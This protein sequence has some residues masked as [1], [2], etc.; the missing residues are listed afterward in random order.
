ML[1]FA[2]TSRDLH[3]FTARRYASAGTSYAPVSVGL[4]VRLRLSQVGILSKWIERLV[5]FGMEAYFD[6]SYIL[7]EVQVSTKIRALPSGTFS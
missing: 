1:L 7:K 4:S 6:R 2:S 3:V 5:C